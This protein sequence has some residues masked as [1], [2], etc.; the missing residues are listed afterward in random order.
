[1]TTTVTHGVFGSRFFVFVKRSVFLAVTDLMCDPTLSSLQLVDE[2]LG[3]PGRAGLSV[4]V[5]E[6][7]VGNSSRWKD[8]ETAAAAE[9][10]RRGQD[11]DGGGG[12]RTHGDPAAVQRWR[13]QPLGR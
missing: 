13:Q 4:N 2:L 7:P 11:D 5:F 6:S 1:M 9:E 8:S 10:S 12:V 3:P